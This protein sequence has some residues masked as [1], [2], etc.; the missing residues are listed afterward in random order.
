MYEIVPTCK[1]TT[2]DFI[3][4]FA[5]NVLEVPYKKEKN[6]HATLFLAHALYEVLLT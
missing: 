4:S 6:L 3:L 2:V 1:L 5:V